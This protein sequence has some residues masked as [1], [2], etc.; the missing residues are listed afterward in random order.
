MNVLTANSGMN[1]PL[2]SGHD[3]PQPRPELVVV[4]V[5]PITSTRN[6]PSVVMTERMRTNRR[7][8][9][10]SSLSRTVDALDVLDAGGVEGEDAGSDMAR[11]PR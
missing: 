9:M 6:M 3:P 1:W 11:R 10:R 2:Q 5:T 8:K 4:T 7:E